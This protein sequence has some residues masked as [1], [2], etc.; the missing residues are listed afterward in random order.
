MLLGIIL[1]AALSFST[2]PWVVQDYERSYVYTVGFSLIHGFRMPLFFLISGFFTA[3]LWRKRG[4]RALIKHRALRIL[5]P[6][7]IGLVTIVP[8]SNIV[9]VIASATTS[10]QFGLDLNSAQARLLA[11]VKT[12]DSQGIKKAISDGADPNLPSEEDG[13]TPLILAVVTNQSD[14]VDELIEN[15]ADVQQT[16]LTLGNSPLHVA[17]FLGR[18]K[19]AASLLDAGADPTKMNNQGETSTDLL[20]ITWSIT[21]WIAASIQIEIEQDEVLRGRKAIAEKLGINKQPLLFASDAV[22]NDRNSNTDE[23]SASNGQK[24]ERESRWQALFIMPVF[25]HLWFLW[26]LCWLVTGFVF[27]ALLAKKMNWRGLPVSLIASPISYLWLVPLTSF[28]QMD[29]N[30]NQFG[31]ETSI[32]LLP[33]PHVLLY[34]SI[35]FGFGVLYYDSADDQA[36]LGRRWR[37]TLPIALFILFPIAFWSSAS[38]QTFLPNHLSLDQVRLIT[39]LLQSLF[40]WMITFGLMGLF[41]DV[42]HRESSRMRYISDSSYWLYLAHLPLVV[43]LQALVCRLPIPSFLKFL[44]V[45]VV[46]ILV[47]LW[48]YEKLVRYTWIGKILNGPR[49]RPEPI[50]DAILVEASGN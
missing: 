14:S 48:S 43:G 33:I 9:Y 34:Y 40:A 4:L 50:V 18:D 5:L 41:H 49:K 24:R 10:N 38:P 3:M 35:F 42:M 45:C 30:G 13:S 1:H 6:C 44:F 27:Y 36:R 15:G 2:L 47:L 25:G 26:F 7:M 11:S 31:P 12:G 20:T 32:G 39:V 23:N 29:M 37:W 17:C 19:I 28:F 22:A 16:D 21:E 8:L 46:S